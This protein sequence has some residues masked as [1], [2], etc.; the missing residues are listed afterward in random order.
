[1][2]TWPWHPPYRVVR[3]STFLLALSPTVC[4]LIYFS[5]ATDGQYSSEMELPARRT[6][7]GAHEP[8]VTALTPRCMSSA[9]FRCRNQQPLK[10]GFHS[11]PSSRWGRRTGSGLGLV[12]LTVAP[13]RFSV[14]PAHENPL[15]ASLAPC[16]ESAGSVVTHICHVGSQFSHES[17]Y[18]MFTVLRR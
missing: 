15:T 14:W 5:G 16:P 12:L 17:Q 4:T 6:Q 13:F 7:V 10:T 2:Q 8:L 3:E 1:M 11:V 9:C 18:C